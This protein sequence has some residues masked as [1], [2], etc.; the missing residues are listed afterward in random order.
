MCL[1][2]VVIVDD[3][4]ESDDNLAI[5]SSIEIIWSLGKNCWVVGTRHIIVDFH[6]QQA[7]RPADK[8]TVLCRVPTLD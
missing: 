1:F 7:D 8:R 5:L 2:V 3:D 4:V 6:Q